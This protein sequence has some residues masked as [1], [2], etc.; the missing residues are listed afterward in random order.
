VATIKLYMA[1]TMDVVTHRASHAEGRSRC[2][3]RCPVS[4]WT[5]SADSGKEVAWPRIIRVGTDSIFRY[6]W[7]WLMMVSKTSLPHASLHLPRR[8]KT[9]GSGGKSDGNDL[10]RSQPIPLTTRACE[11]CWWSS[12]N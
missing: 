9:S 2:A 6:L 8:Q 7:L 3:A 11:T 5:V 4:G 12:G 1:S 10:C